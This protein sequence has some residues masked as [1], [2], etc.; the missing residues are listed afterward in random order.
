MYSSCLFEKSS[1]T[2]SILIPTLNFVVFVQKK[3]RLIGLLPLKI[4]V[5]I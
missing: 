1:V 5:G 4:V 2:K 3:A